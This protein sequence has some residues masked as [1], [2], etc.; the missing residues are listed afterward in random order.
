M[1]STSTSVPL[2]PNTHTHTYTHTPL[3]PGDYTAT[4]V[5]FFFDR[6]SNRSCVNV[7]IFPDPIMEDSEYFCGNLDTFDASVFLN[8]DKTNVTIMDGGKDSI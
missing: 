4:T 3:A 1:N 2:L 6:D 5:M 7:P 8:P